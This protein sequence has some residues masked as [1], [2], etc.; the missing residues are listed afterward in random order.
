MSNTN[1]E[2]QAVPGA[3]APGNGM[4]ISAVNMYA[5]TSVMYEHSLLTLTLIGVSEYGEGKGLYYLSEL[6]EVKGLDPDEGHDFSD[7]VDATSDDVPS[8]AVVRLPWAAYAGQV[9]REGEDDVQAAVVGTLA[10]ALHYEAGN[11]ADE[12][13]HLRNVRMGAVLVER[14]VDVAHEAHAA[15]S[16]GRI[17]ASIGSNQ[18]MAEGTRYMHEM[19]RS[20]DMCGM[21]TLLQE[22]GESEEKKQKI[23]PISPVSLA[24]GGVTFTAL[25]PALARILLEHASE[26][27]EYVP[28]ITAT[29]NLSPAGEGMS[30]R[31]GFQEQLH[32]RM[33]EGDEDAHGF[34]LRE[35]IASDGIPTSIARVCAGALSLTQWENRN[36]GDEDEAKE[37]VTVGVCRFVDITHVDLAGL[38]PDNLDE[39]VDKLAGSVPPWVNG[40]E[41]NAEALR[42]LLRTHL[43]A[44]MDTENTEDAAVMSDDMKNTLR[45][46]LKGMFD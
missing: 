44:H 14:W 5:A 27:T 3:Y 30:N 11:E 6:R 28:T 46:M 4:L 10:M 29:L 7:Y 41:S 2:W 31:S 20:L 19:I 21:F 1:R 33:Q 45:D 13:Y 34:L 12:Q 8:V 15:M 25:H 39:E 35:A 32:E 37:M 42:S 36:D 40:S 43:A 22:A 16:S 38:T 9:Q 24:G 18:Y 26:D 23:N 17:V